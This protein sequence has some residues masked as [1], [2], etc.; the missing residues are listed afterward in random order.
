MG[1]NM[2]P[3]AVTRRLVSSRCKPVQR[4][5]TSR[6]EDLPDTAAKSMPR[7]SQDTSF[8][9]WKVEVLD[10]SFTRTE[11]LAALARRS[12]VSTRPHTDAATTLRVCILGE[13]SVTLAVVDLR[14]T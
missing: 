14:C 9:Q 11:V 4:E 12:S 6:T 7:L 8:C 13:Y 2:L 10:D 5:F 1:V 3:P